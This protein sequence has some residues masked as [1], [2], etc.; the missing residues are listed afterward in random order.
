MKRI[1]ALLIATVWAVA[2]T[3]PGYVD[4]PD[5]SGLEILTPS[6]SERKTAKIRLNNGLEAYLISDPKA[7]QSGAALAMEVGSW[8]DDPNY[9]GIAHFTEHLLFLGSEAYPDE[10]CYERQVLDNGGIFNAY[11]FTDRTVYMFTVNNDAFS[12]TIDMFS[13]MF[14]DPLFN[15]SG[16]ARELHAV[17]Q[18][19]DKNIENDMNRTW[20]IIK[21]TGNQ[22]HPNALFS[23]GNAK[24]LGGIPPQE[25][26]RWYQENYS[27]DR[28]HLILYS[29]LPIEELK[30]M[31]SRHFSAVPKSN[32]KLSESTEKLFSERQEGHIIAMKP[33]KDLRSLGIIWELPK[34]F[35]H[36]FDD[37]SGELLGYILGGRH[38]NSL[39]S[40]LKREELIDNISSGMFR[41][42]KDSGIFSIDFE[43][44]PQGAEQFETVIERCF[45]TLNGLKA[46]GIPPYIFQEIK[47]MAKVDYEYQSRV[48]P[49]QFVAA[50]AHKLIDEPLETYPLKTTMPT[51]YDLEETREFLNLLSPETA[52]YFLTAS[53]E[54][55]GIPTEKKEKWSGAEYSIRKFSDKTLANWSG[56]SPHP[57][58][59][60]PKQNSFIPNNL[61]LV[62]QPTDGEAL[63]T[64]K[65]KKLYQGDLGELYFWED[66]QYQVPEISWVL[67][68][69][70]PYIDGSAR[71]AVMMDL[72]RYALDEN[73]AATQTYA[74]AASLSLS[75]TVADNK[76]LILVGGYSEKAPLLLEETLRKAKK[77]HMTK[78]E[79][80]QYTT[81]LKSSY[82]NQAKA[83]PVA[84]AFEIYLDLIYNN[85]PKHPAKLSALEAIQYEDYLA[86]AEKL[87]EESYVEALLIGNMTE[88]D[89]H[90]IWEITSQQLS[91][92]PYPKKNHERK[93]M[94]TL[95]SLQG[96]YKIPSQTD[97]LG[98]AA[99]LAIQEGGMTFPKKASHVV[100]GKG[101]QE[102]F[103]D[104]LRTK[105]Q[106]AYIAQ[107]QSFEDEEQLFNLF[108]VQ[109]STHQP[110]EL[111]A[112]FELFIENYVKDFESF[113][114]EGRFEV[115]RSN[116]ITLLETPPTNLAKMAMELNGLAFTH[117]GDFE[118]K[119]KIIAALKHLSYEEFKA[120]TITFLSRK[121]P[122]RI[123]IMLEGKQPEG[124]AFRYEGITANTLKTEGTYISLP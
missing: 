109:S 37:R 96:P 9:A 68:I 103:F 45:Q 7:D 54:L 83:M 124:K 62:T 12:T 120:D 76:L 114:S 97:C 57:Q 33:F 89:A 28:A 43:L 72:F 25:V 39:Y 86:F 65:P 70:T 67:N 81:S 30:A 98:S 8:N 119:E 19:H 100:L 60:L 101:L 80:D 104:T 26:R 50:H 113:I 6:L 79:F 122:R 44:T 105:Q 41:L 13:H 66:S 74:E 32:L 48:A 55:S 31:A 4:I 36:N 34:S 49:F 22:N 24:T 82:A 18:E 88:K 61:K 52:S 87:F 73:L 59:A 69:S 46:S 107:A 77:C 93:Q 29:T 2:E 58:I 10:S 95:S 117:K 99:I 5:Q 112:R 42:S 56:N 40:Q 111:V 123:A 23:T 47:K 14:I 53:P 51:H 3:T 11:T 38:E 1:I 20:M 75:T 84:Q 78:E 63:V 91:Y 102:D 108:I 110:D 64:P 21:E 121:N 17:D 71:S 94:L 106:T 115:L 15:P 116:M 27:A 35:I 90:R 16:V 118:R 85:A 92:M